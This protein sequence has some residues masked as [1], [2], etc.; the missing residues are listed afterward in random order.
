VTG[1]LT[2][3]LPRLADRAVLPAEEAG[4]AFAAI[5]D[6]GEHP[7]AV[8]AFLTALRMRGETLE[9]IAAAAAA[10]RARCVKV[11]APADAID[12]CG[13]GGDGA[14][15][16]NVSTCATFAV[17]GLGVPVAKHGN[18][19]QSSK[20]GAADVLEALGV[21]L[22]LSPDAA[23][24]VLARAGSVFLFAQ[25]HHPA[26]RHVAPV[27]QAL[28]FRTI[29]NLLGPLT[30]PASVT[31]QL[32]GV[33]AP[34]WL[35]PAAEALARL[36]SQRA[37]VVHGAGG[38]DEISTLGPTEAILLADGALTPLTLTP[39]DLGLPRARPED[40]AGGTP[41]DNARILRAVL[42]GEKGPHADIVAAN[43]GGALFVAGRARS[44]AEGV[45]L[46][47][48]SLAEGLAA[49]ALARLIAE[50]NRP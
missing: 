35:G 2:A 31:R 38:L 23:A 17:A 18:R 33:Y 8:G 14:G 46:A 50:S 45:A 39:E 22:T 48:Q 32:M 15:S 9:E 20:S 37:L 21:N 40:L 5:M 49:A 6:G 27:R 10:M 13:T 47:R 1:V 19:A 28:K 43:A 34:A 42:G 25:N 24:R 3:L 44:V 12:M 16:F 36:G 29:F 26:M 4:R 41:E 30:S 11:A 7:A